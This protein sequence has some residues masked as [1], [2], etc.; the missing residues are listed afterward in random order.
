MK[1]S[2]CASV[3]RYSSLPPITYLLTN[4]ISNNLISVQ[5]HESLAYFHVYNHN[6]LQAKYTNILR[7]YKCLQHMRVFICNILHHC[8]YLS[9]ILIILRLRH[10]SQALMLRHLWHML[11]VQRKGNGGGGRGG[12]MDTFYEDG[13]G[14][15]AM[16]VT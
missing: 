8:W 5:N 16:T 15:D 13:L 10:L 14:V 3:H 7:E 9:I 11:R 12:D 4:Q 2:I 6:N 1:F